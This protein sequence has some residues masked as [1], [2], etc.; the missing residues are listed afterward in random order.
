MSVRQEKDACAASGMTRIKENTGANQSADSS[1][2]LGLRFIVEP[3]GPALTS[4]EAAILKELRPAGI[5]LRRRNFIQGEAYPGWLSSY[6]KLLDEV[7]FAIG[8]ERIAVSVDHEGGKVHRFPPPI[9]CFPYPAFY[10]AEPEAV[11]AV[12]SAMARELSALGVN[13]SFAPTADI[14]SNPANPVINQRA[15]GSTVAQVSDAAIR[16]ASALRAGG[17]TPCAKHFPGHGDTTTDSH[18]SLPTVNRTLAELEQR[19]L[20]PFAALIREQVEMVMSAHIELPLVDPGVPA[21]LSRKIMTGILR[22]KLGFTGVTIADALGMKGVSEKHAPGAVAI[23]AHKAGI[24]LMLMVGDS[25]SLRDALLAKRELEKFAESCS[26]TDMKEIKESQQRISTLLMKLPQPAV[27][28][29]DDGVLET[30]GKL[31]SKL[32]SNQQWACFEFDPIGFT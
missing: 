14:H 16:F 9:T 11:T 29:L 6:K 23:P 15:F 8:R 21:T 19:E 10:A 28:P 32:G 7:R 25:V 3:S 22:Q 17:I 27:V 30:H 24:D 2:D 26:A 5:M 20:A 12:A 4:D 13:V 31:A 18:T 1:L